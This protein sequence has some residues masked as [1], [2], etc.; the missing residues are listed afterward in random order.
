MIKLIRSW[1]IFWITTQKERTWRLC[2]S[3]KVKVYINLAK[4]AFMLKSKKVI[5]FCAELVVD[6]CILMSLSNSTLL[7]KLIKLKE[8]MCFLDSKTRQLFKTSHTTSP[9][10][11]EKAAQLVLHKDHQV[12]AKDKDLPAQIE[13][14]PYHKENH[15]LYQ[16]E[17]QEMVE[18]AIERVQEPKIKHW[19][20]QPIDWINFQNEQ[21]S[22]S[23][24]YNIIIIQNKWRNQSL[25]IIIFLIK[26]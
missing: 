24:N 16:T 25:S 12:Q 14:A 26:I 3:E 7:V 9:N 23:R 8:E 10:P 19:T 15:H 5:K 18:W 2:S 22:I 20:I 13:R 6:S 1:A 17:N 11:W 21:V 4:N